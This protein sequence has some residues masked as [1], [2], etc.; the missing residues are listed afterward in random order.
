[1]AMQIWY[2]CNKSENM[3]QSHVVWKCDYHIVVTAA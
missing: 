3:K 1:M 2:F